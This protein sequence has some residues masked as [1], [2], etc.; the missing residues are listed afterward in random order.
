MG[1]PIEKRDPRFNSSYRTLVI[2]GEA[3]DISWQNEQTCQIYC[4]AYAHVKINAK[5]TVS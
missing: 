2:S 5:A 1:C 4:V 3:N